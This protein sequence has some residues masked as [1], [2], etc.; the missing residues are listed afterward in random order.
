MKIFADRNDFK[1][2][3]ELVVLY[4]ML[5]KEPIESPENEGRFNGAKEACDKYI[6]YV[7][8][9]DEADV[10]VLSHKFCGKF[11]KT[12]KKIWCFY[13]DDCD[14][15]FDLPDN[16]TLFRTS[17]YKFTEIINTILENNFIIGINYKSVNTKG[18]YCKSCNYMLGYHIDTETH[19]LIK[20][21]LI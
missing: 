13:N 10:V 1:F 18:I 9:E 15:S 20:D 16:V 19:F 21:K 8:S 6:T 14:K 4:G 5:D 12:S 11:P 2:C 17:F 7:S 3:S